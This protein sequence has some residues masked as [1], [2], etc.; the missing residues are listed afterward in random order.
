MDAPP[1]PDQPDKPPTKGVFKG[2]PVR[3]RSLSTSQK[4]GSNNQKR[5]KTEDTPAEETEGPA[6]EDHAASASSNR[7]PSEA[8]IFYKTSKKEY[9]DM[10]A[11][12][13]LELTTALAEAATAKKDAVIEKLTKK[14]EQLTASTKTARGVAREAKQYAKSVEDESTKTAKKLQDE[15]AIANEKAAESLVKF[16]QQKDIAVLKEQV[17]LSHLFVFYSHD[18]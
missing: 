10:Y 12:C 16:E 2:R 9:A 11:K 4:K 6:H 7:L 5:R 14:I 15:L 17:S 1:P 3:G 13:Q 8:T 18:I